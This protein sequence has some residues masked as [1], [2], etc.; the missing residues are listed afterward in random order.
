MQES[1][2]QT[3]SGTRLRNEYPDGSGMIEEK[4]WQ[5]NQMNCFEK[6]AENG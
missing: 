4:R 1:N 2:F 5:F 3:C 6:S